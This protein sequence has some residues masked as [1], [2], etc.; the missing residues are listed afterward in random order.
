MRIRRLFKVQGPR[1]KG[2]EERRMINDKFI[3]VLCRVEKGAL[4]EKGRKDAM[5]ME[6]ESKGRDRDRE[7]VEQ[8]QGNT[9]DKQ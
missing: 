2:Q 4:L 8:E 1:I 3:P 5:E 7:R 6:R 9:W